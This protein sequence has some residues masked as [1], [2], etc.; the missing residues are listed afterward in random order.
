MIGKSGLCIH[1]TLVKGIGG[2]S[3]IGKM[4]FFI[5]TYVVN[6]SFFFPKWAHLSLNSN[7]CGS[8]GRKRNDD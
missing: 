6:L 7:H 1:V 2:G 5:L 4:H 8:Y 3:R